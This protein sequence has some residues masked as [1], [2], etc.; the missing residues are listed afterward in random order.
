[1]GRGPLRRPVR[2]RVP[3]GGRRDRAAGP[4]TRGDRPGSGLRHRRAGGGDP[5]PWRRGRPGGQ[6][7]RDGRRGQQE[8]PAV[9]RP[10]RRSRLQGRRAGRRG[11][12]QRGPAL[13][14]PAGRGRPV[15]AGGAEAGRPLRRRNGRCQQCG[16]RHRRAPAR[17][18]RTRTGRGH[19]GA[20]VLPRARR[21]RRPAGGQRLPGQPRGAL[22]PPDRPRRLPRGRRGLAPD[23]RRGAHRARPRGRPP[24]GAAARRELAAP[25]LLRD[26]RWYAD[27]WRLRFVAVVEESGR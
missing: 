19:A 1:M 26:G 3:P 22:P 24:G 15:G 13:D 4:A 23:V 25:E 2:L 9:G 8:A 5:G 7:P 27:Y 18:G 17:A 11:L 20:V 6:R 21:V 10:G 16:R 14:D 12:L